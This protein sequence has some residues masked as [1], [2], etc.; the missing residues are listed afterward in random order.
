[1][2]RGGRQG[3]RFAGKVVVITGAA[4][5][6]GGATTAFEICQV[7]VEPGQVGFVEGKL[8]DAWLASPPGPQRRGGVRPSEHR[9]WMAFLY[10]PSSTALLARLALVLC[11]VS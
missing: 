5:D 7:G 4:G 1:M 10:C 11:S 8:G 9:A 2:Q 3:E 6:I